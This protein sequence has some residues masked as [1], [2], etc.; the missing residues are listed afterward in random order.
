VKMI[1]F[2]GL[3][4]GFGIW[5]LPRLTRI[6]H[7][8]PISQGVLAFAVIILLTYGMAAELLGGMAAITGT[9]LAGLMF[10][11]MPEKK[12]IENGLRSLAYGFFVPI[13]FVSIGLGVNL[14]GLNI[15]TIWIALLVALV[16]ILGKLIGA[17]LGARLG[18]LTWLE[19]LQLSIGMV[20]RGEVG[21]IVAQLGLVQ[22]L[23]DDTIFSVVVGMVLITT[24][25]T[26]PLLRAAF[27]KGQQRSTATAPSE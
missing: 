7:R 23:L 24:L 16:A 8:L 12:D 25:V 14:S 3:S 2:L 9:F 22:G 26:P 5:V 1:L 20:S 21:L 13:F 6:I 27:Q 4:A 17:G 18:G 15:R 11:R 10:S 19:S